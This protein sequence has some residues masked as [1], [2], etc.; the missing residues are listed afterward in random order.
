MPRGTLGA[1]GTQGV[2]NE[3][4]AEHVVGKLDRC[5]LVPR[6]LSEVV[7]PTSISKSCVISP[8]DSQ[9]MPGRNRGAMGA[10]PGWTW[11]WRSM[12]ASLGY[13]WDLCWGTPLPTAPKEEGQTPGSPSF[14]PGFSYQ[15]TWKLKRPII[16]P[17]QLCPCGTLLAVSPAWVLSGA[18]PNGNWC[19]LQQPGFLV[20]SPDMALTVKIAQWIPW[21]TEHWFLVQAPL[22]TRQQQMWQLWLGFS[23]RG[24]RLGGRECS[25][26]KELVGAIG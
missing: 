18:F 7:W 5:S 23:I 26:S 10:G 9:N 19:S 17:E 25:D 13:G 22:A 6:L 8:R 14:G 11:S 24:F 3:H 16:Y 15:Q 21:A 20:T 2:C 12:L 4:R 1:R